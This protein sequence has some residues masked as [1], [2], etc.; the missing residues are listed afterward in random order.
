MK[1]HQ[2]VIVAADLNVRVVRMTSIKVDN[3]MSE[4][5]QEKCL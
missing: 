2:E 4:I 1:G 5:V 3:T